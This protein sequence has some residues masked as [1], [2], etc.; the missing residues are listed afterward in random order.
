MKKILDR[1]KSTM[2]AC[3]ICHPGYEHDHNVLT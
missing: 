3:Q 2:L 1:P